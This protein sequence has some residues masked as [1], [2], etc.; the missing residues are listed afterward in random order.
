VGKQECGFEKTRLARTIR[1]QEKVPPRRQIELGLPDQ[2]KILDT[3]VGQ[4]H[5][6]PMWAVGPVR[7]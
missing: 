7:A 3:Q 6:P 1:T 4:F 5:R 2:P